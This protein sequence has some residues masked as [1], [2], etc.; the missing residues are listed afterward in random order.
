MG[1]QL[2]A[3]ALLVFP[4]LGFCHAFLQRKMLSYY[5]GWACGR[6]SVIR[7]WKQTRI[8]KSKPLLV[9]ERLGWSE[10]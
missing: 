6:Q 7:A 9:C 8:P 10:I 4:L 3:V 5:R 2:G 1:T